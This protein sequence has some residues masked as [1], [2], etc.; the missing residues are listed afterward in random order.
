MLLDQMIYFL[1]ILD[2]MFFV[3]LVSS[4]DHAVLGLTTFYTFGDNHRAHAFYERARLSMALRLVPA[5][6]PPFDELNLPYAIQAKFPTP[7]IHVYYASGH[8]AVEA[9][10]QSVFSF[11]DY[12]DRCAER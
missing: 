10:Y 12:D 7:F 6:V 3:N 8:T 9:F 5:K 2:E 1:N 4:V 11:A